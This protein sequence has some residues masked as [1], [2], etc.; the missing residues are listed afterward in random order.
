MNQMKIL[1]LFFSLSCNCVMA[2]A[3]KQY[4][5][6]ISLRYQDWTDQI[7]GL[8]GNKYWGTFNFTYDYKEPFVDSERKIDLTIST[9]DAGGFFF[10][11]K[12][13]QFTTIGVQQEFSAGVLI[14]D[15]VEIDRVWGLGK[16]N[17][18][19]NI[20][21][22][23]PG[24]AGL[25]GVRYK[26][27][28]SK[29]IKFDTFASF[30]YVPELNPSLKINKDAGT[31]TSRS[32]W[33]EAPAATTQ[34]GGLDRQIFYTVH[35]PDIQDIVLRPQAGINLQFSLF[36]NLHIS[37][38]YIKKPENNLSNTATLI[39]DNITFTPYVDVY[40]KIYYHELWGGQVTF[41]TPDRDIQLYGS[42]LMSQPGDKPE[43]DQDIINLGYAFRL[44][45]KSEAYT[46][47]G[48]R[49]LFL[50]GESHFGYIARLTDYDESN[51][52]ERKPRWN[53]ALN[54]ALEF[55]FFE[56][57]AFET[58]FF[59]DMLNY[60]RLASVKLRYDYSSFLAASLGLNAVTSPD[61]GVG[62]W[63]DFRNND[64]LFTEVSI[65]F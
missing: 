55:K 26:F 30:I 46:G 2:S 37:S 3:L 49:Y 52:L 22:F 39:V 58:E 11:V 33:A 7:G 63:A 51:L 60:D 34:V 8:E 64:A 31:V 32:P 13:A 36:E 53:Q 48:I 56:S 29:N 45:K 59:Y 44:D 23:N 18:R 38:Y 25:P 4:Y 27:N 5:G 57:F 17:N 14:L 1:I 43:N 20:D 47:A 41:E 9:N 50:N 16:L 15:W 61:D 6:D 35:I 40:P 62:Y 24:Q 19:V 12:E 42:Y 10:A 21:F 65:L 54:F 28:V